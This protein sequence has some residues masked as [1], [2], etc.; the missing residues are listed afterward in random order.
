MFCRFWPVRNYSWGRCETLSSANSD[1]SLLKQLL[2][3]EGFAGLKQ[4]TEERYYRCA[5]CLL[6]MLPELSYCAYFAVL[7]VPCCAM[8]CIL[9]HAA[10]VGPV[11]ELA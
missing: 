10:C 8:L 9:C 5:L 6:H 3:E 2:F 1:I 4:G 7:A 11:F